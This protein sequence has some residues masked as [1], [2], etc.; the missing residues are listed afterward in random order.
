MIS[1]LVGIAGSELMPYVLCPRPGTRQKSHT[2]LIRVENNISFPPFQIENNMRVKPNTNTITGSTANEI[3]VSNNVLPGMSAEPG[4]RVQNIR[5]LF[6]AAA[7]RSQK[8]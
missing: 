4:R 1:L 2:K 8:W 3:A 5:Q 7:H 6:T